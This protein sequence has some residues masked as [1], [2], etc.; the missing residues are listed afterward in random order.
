MAGDRFCIIDIQPSKV[1]TTATDETWII[2]E[3]NVPA[4]FLDADGGYASNGNDIKIYTN[5]EMTD[6]IPR[7]VRHI[8]TNNNPALGKLVVATKVPITSSVVVTKL[9][10]EYHDPA[11]S[12]YAVDHPK[13]QRAAYA[14]ETKGVFP[15]RLISSNL[16]DAT[17]SANECVPVGSHTE[18]DGVIGK[19][20][21]FTSALGHAKD[22]SQNNL[23]I[24]DNLSI[25]CIFIAGST[26]NIWEI[27]VMYSQNSTSP[28]ASV[29]R[30]FLSVGGWSAGGRY[31][32][33]NF[34]ASNGTI[35]REW[36]TPSDIITLSAANHIACT[37]NTTDGAKF[38]V[39]GVLQ[40]TS[41]SE[42]PITIDTTKDTIYI[43]GGNWSGTSC[44][45][46][47]D[48]IRIY[49]G[50]PDV[51]TAGQIKSI[52]ENQMNPSTFM[53]PSAGFP[54][55]TA[56]TKVRKKLLD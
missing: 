2:T 35:V 52:Y 7:H 4:E 45:S 17:A 46:G 8:E 5:E 26:L 39:N 14:D 15:M 16:P 28:S 56:V 22:T 20:V 42:T 54:I 18:I 37:Y 12:D 31:R 3:E 24:A 29:W 33:L 50:D 25:E 43:G 55:V 36:W 11:A 13:G 10:V 1:E 23:N 27:P 9:W 44:Q 34:V 51:R 49:E 21:K 48:E 40:T 19:A 38:Y 32:N 6:E 47:V 30:Y 53:I 41:H